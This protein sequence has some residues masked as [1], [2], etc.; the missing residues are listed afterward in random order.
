[1]YLNEAFF[2]GFQSSEVMI[3]NWFFNKSPDPYV[4]F[5]VR[6]QIYKRDD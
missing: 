3:F 5:P 6:S 4:W 2:K 1:M